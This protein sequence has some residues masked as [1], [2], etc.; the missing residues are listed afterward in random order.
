MS[1]RIQNAPNLLVKQT[2]KGCLQEMMGCEAQSEFNIATMEDQRLNILYAIEEGNCCVRTFCPIIRDFQMKV[3]EHKEAPPFL[4]FERPMKCA[5]GPLKCCCYQE[6]T[7]RSVEGEDLGGV[8]EQFY[9]CV[10]SFSIF[11][12]SGQQTHELKPPTCLGGLCID[13]CAEGLCRQPFRI[14]KIGEPGVN[15]EGDGKI[16]KIWGGIMKEMFTDADTFELD[17]PQKA[18]YATKAR[19]L[20]AVFLL[21]QLFYE[22]KNNN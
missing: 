13:C 5:G 4:E 20:G 10:P 18:D 6:V 8:R 7:A 17:F 11:D 12:G 19:L 15:I 16:T 14:H 2:R 1:E 21:N 22:N 9:V 3:S